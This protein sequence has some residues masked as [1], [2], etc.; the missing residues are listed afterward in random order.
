MARSDALAIIK[1]YEGKRPPSLDLFLDYVGLNEE[2]FYE[3]AMSHGVSPYQHDPGGDI[4]GTK[5][6]DFD[7]WPKHG[8]MPRDE[9]LVQLERWHHR[10]RPFLFAAAR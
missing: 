1:K 5:V 2:E 7:K 10:N 8:S 6:H 9:A 3:I 4:T